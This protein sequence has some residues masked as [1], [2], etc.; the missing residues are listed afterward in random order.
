MYPCISEAIL[1]LRIT[2][3]SFGARAPARKISQRF[4]LLIHAKIKKAAT[5]QCFDIIGILLQCFRQFF[6]FFL[7]LKRMPE[8][9]WHYHKEVCMHDALLAFACNVR[10]PFS[11]SHGRSAPHPHPHPHHPHHL[12]QQFSFP[13]STSF[14][15]VFASLVFCSETLTKRRAT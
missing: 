4:L 6:H 14:C 11:L 12:L 1:R 7:L 15:F 5:V 10:D 9:D 13:F 2:S 8:K 3:G